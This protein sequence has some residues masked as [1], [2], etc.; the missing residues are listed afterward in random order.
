MYSTYHFDSATEITSDILDAIKIAFKS[1]PITLTIAQDRDDTNYLLSNPLNRAALL[2]SIEE[3]RQG[4]S[5][6]FKESE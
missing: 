2:Q 5:I 4:L 6:P 3:D 1:S